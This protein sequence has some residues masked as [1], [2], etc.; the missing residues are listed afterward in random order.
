MRRKLPGTGFKTEACAHLFFACDAHIIGPT[1]TTSI[2]SF[3]PFSLST[4][5]FPYLFYLFIFIYIS[6]IFITMKNNSDNIIFKFQ[7]SEASSNTHPFSDSASSAN[8][9]SMDSPSSV[10]DSIRVAARSSVIDS[11]RGCGLS[12]IRIDKEELK[13]I[14]LLP[15]YLRL[16]MRDSINSKDPNAGD[17]HLEGAENAESPECPII[18]FINSR[19]GGRHGPELKERLQE[20]MSRE[21]VLVFFS[22]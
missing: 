18:V 12:G 10:G 5:L 20:L 2:P 14:I 21:Q 6:F 7:S 8:F 11:F 22:N 15:Q 19:S 3:L 17:H 1:T 13:R 16:A 4:F 9:D